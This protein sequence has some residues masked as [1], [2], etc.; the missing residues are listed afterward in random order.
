MRT[1]GASTRQAGEQSRL[2]HQLI[3]HRGL[4]EGKY[5]LFF[6]T[7][8][9]EFLPAGPQPDRVEETSGYVLDNRGRV[10]S[11]WLGWDS[12]SQEAALTT[13]REVPPEPHW[14]GNPEYRRARKRVGLAP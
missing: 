2:L 11:F 9:G 1:T 5:A 12:A 13:W 7:G 3:Q 14:S 10:F 4:K 8:E 6:V